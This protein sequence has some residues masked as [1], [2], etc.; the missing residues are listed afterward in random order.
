[1]LLNLLMNACD[2][3][4]P[5]PKVTVSASFAPEGPPKPSWGPYVAST[6]SPEHWNAQWSG[7]RP[8]VLISIHDDGKGITPEVLRLLFNEQITTKQHNHGTGLGL[9]LCRDVLAAHGGTLVIESSFGVG[10]T[11]TVIV[12]ANTTT[13]WARDDA[14]R[15]RS[16]GAVPLIE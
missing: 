7:G 10:T 6:V 9:L 3:T 1:V 2:A 8:A 16:V 12:P 11:T 4:D 5:H 15:K 14:L 13:A